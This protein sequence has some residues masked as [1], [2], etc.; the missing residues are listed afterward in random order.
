MNHRIARRFSRFAAAAFS[1]TTAAALITSAP[2]QARTVRRAVRAAAPATF[3]DIRGG[4]YGPWLQS[5][6][7]DLDKEWAQE[8]PKVYGAKFKPM[9]SFYPY[10]TERLPPACG[11]DRAGSYRELQGN[12]FYCSYNDYIAF[13]EETL[14]PELYQ[15]QGRI[16][17]AMVIAHEFG[18]AVARRA[19]VRGPTVMQEQQADCFA[20]AWVARAASGKASG[21]SV[22][23]KEIDDAIVSML[24][25]RDRPGTDPSGRG[26][27]GNGFDRISAFQQGF[28][29]GVSRCAKIPK[30]PLTLTTS[31]FTSLDDASR[32]GDLE[33]DKSIELSRK[34]LDA[35]IA[36]SVPAADRIGQ[37]KLDSASD[38]ASERASCP[39]ATEL[40]SPNLVLCAATD[41][42]RTLLV[43]DEAAQ[44]N[45]ERIGDLALTA[46]LAQG[47][48]YLVQQA[49]GQ[50]LP[51]DKSQ[52][53]NARLANLTND[54]LVGGFIRDATVCADCR[55]PRAR[56]VN[57]SRF[58]WSGPV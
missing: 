42:T 28:E 30:E 32:G 39:A 19:G 26:T 46:F 21:L 56:S 55:K 12:A 6:A 20:G 31:A 53:A 35:W 57:F 9:N 49:N 18:H 47:Y 27:H 37:L 50:P 24:L 36:K 29:G 2:A 44:N 38:F 10:S 33:F 13:D 34:L 15:S 58:I 1:V 41:G 25:V 52:T 43:N 11:G 14:F 54:C 45:Y 17:V 40:R 48:A 51:D 3:A 16:G 23:V 8:F 7:A 22:S 4:P 5:V